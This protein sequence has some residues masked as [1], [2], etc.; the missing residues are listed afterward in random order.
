MPVAVQLFTSSSLATRKAKSD[1]AKLQL[2][3]DVKKIEYEEA[4]T[5]DA[6]GAW[7]SRVLIVLAY[8]DRSCPRSILQCS[9][10]AAPKCLSRLPMATACCHRCTVR[11]VLLLLPAHTSFNS[12]LP[13][14]QPQLHVNYKYLGNADEVQELEDWGELSYLLAGEV[15]P[16]PPELA[17]QDQAAAGHEMLVVALA[18]TTVTAAVTQTPASAPH[19]AAELPEPS[20]PPLLV[21]AG[22]AAA[23]IE[24]QN[25]QAAAAEP[26]PVQEPEEDVSAVAAALT[27]AAIASAL[28]ASEVQEREAAVAAGREA[29]EVAA[30]LAATA[31]ARALALHEPPPAAVAPEQQQGHCAVSAANSEQQQEQRGV[32]S[33]LPEQQQPASGPPIAASAAAAAALAAVRSLA[34]Q[35]IDR[36]AG[37]RLAPL[38]FPTSTTASPAVSASPSPIKL[39][40][41]QQWQ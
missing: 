28:A 5:L 41:Q 6:S 30:A 25:Q 23:P 9:P 7:R 14:L 21:D 15:P 32:S 33:P 34:P 20:A 38:S 18:G 10:I 31:V 39:P 11:H 1:A 26:A 36:A 24:Q 16:L 40:Q 4:S 27:A 12:C 35:V 3:L 22:A 13:P 2:L 37:A 29:S 8:P 19:P 17:M